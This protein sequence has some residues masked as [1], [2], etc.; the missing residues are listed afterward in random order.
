VSAVKSTV[1]TARDRRPVNRRATFVTAIALAA[2]FVPSLAAS[3]GVAQA[4]TPT[5]GFAQ[6]YAGTPKYEKYAPTEATSA[7]QVN[8]PLGSKAADWIARK[9]GLN[10]RQAFTAKQYKLFVS[11]KGVGGD[12]AAAKLVDESVRILTN[13]TGNPL[14]ANVNGKVTPIVLGSYGLLVNTAGMLESPANTDAPT[15]QVNTVIAPGGYLGKWCRE[16]GCQA[17]LR[18]LYRSAYTSEVVYGNESQQQSGVAQLVPNVKGGRSSI[19]GMSMAPSIW[20]V[21]FALIY[22]LNPS[23]AANMPAWWTPIPA[24]VA[25]AIAASPTGQVPF[26]EYQS[27]FPGWLPGARGADGECAFLQ[28]VPRSPLTYSNVD[29]VGAGSMLL[30]SLRSAR[31]HPTT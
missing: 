5:T 25:Q 2:L 16:N 10:K 17:S 11:G 20:I 29:A 1:G 13:T 27:S 7:C 23:L 15:R 9:L 31:T 21:N 18:M 30:A 3:Q 26:S 8:R 28:A 14:Y 19:V 12:P 4:A 24:N 6:P 22:T